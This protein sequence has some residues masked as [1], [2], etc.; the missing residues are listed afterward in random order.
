MGILKD[1]KLIKCGRIH[2]TSQHWENIICDG[3]WILTFPKSEYWRNLDLPNSQNY[4]LNYR[5][6]NKSEYK[7]NWICLLGLKVKIWEEACK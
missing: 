7:P 4:F 1:A 6:N 3:D 5:R 2:G